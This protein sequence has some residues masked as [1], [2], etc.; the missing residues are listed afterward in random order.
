MQTL[1]S[2]IRSSGR[3]WTGSAQ[4]GLGAGLA[5]AERA[6]GGAG[7][8]A[9]LR[10]G[11]WLWV[12]G[13]FSRWACLLGNR[14]SPLGRSPEIS[15]G[16]KHLVPRGPPIPGRSGRPQKVNTPCWLGSPLGPAARPG[17]GPLLRPFWRV[18]PPPPAFH[19]PPPS[20]HPLW[21]LPPS[22]AVGTLGTQPLQVSA[23]GAPE[24]R[25]PGRHREA[26]ADAEL[27]APGLL[28]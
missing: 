11:S 3:G 27:A 20:A 19:L 17:P 2:Q 5:G 15:S 10:T 1:G 12:S 4:A 9:R 7:G 16:E 21:P 6:P 25:R 8:E 18:S 28:L 14:Q 13:G 23:L 22:L 24:E 26:E